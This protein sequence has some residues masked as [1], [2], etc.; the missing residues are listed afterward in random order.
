M[1]TR[2]CTD[3][4]RGRNKPRGPRRRNDAFRDR[5][6][7]SSLGAKYGCPSLFCSPLALA[8]SLVSFSCQRALLPDNLASESPIPL[9]SRR[10]SFVRPEWLQDGRHPP[11]KAIKPARAGPSA[12]S[13]ALFRPSFSNLPP[14]A[15]PSSSLCLPPRRPPVRPRRCTGC[16]AVRTIRVLF[17]P[18]LSDFAQRRS[19]VERIATSPLRL[20]TMGSR[21][22]GGRWTSWRPRR[23]LGR[24]T[25]P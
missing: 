22:F 13:F 9:S 6:S 15:S 1:Q 14:T 17:L 8:L 18:V 25:P 21:R 23:S 4:P 2:M 20:S 5:R 24:P 16:R 10:P 7:S 12:S 11:I 19:S 3:H